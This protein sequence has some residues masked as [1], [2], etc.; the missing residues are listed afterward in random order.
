M[1]GEDQEVL[2][3]VSKRVSITCPTRGTHHISI[4]VVNSWIHHLHR[5]IK[6]IWDHLLSRFWIWSW[7]IT[8]FNFLLCPGNFK[9]EN[10]PIVSMCNLCFF[11][12]FHH[13]STHCCA[14]QVFF[15]LKWQLSPFLPSVIFSQRSSMFTGI[16]AISVT[17]WFLWTTIN[18]DQVNN[19]MVPK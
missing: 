4:W 15:L 13:I 3:G 2:S 9:K 6:N 5:T 1:E 19:D 17:Q 8:S 11:L 16:C 10:V 18:I 14:S 7:S 12:Y